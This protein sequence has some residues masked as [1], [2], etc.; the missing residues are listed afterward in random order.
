MEVLTVRKVIGVVCVCTSVHA[1]VCNIS[2][3]LF[4]IVNVDVCTCV[5]FRDYVLL[6]KML[7][8][9]IVLSSN[10]SMDE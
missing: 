8:K 4:V 7:L 5:I 6:L 2:K 1:H 10:S 9:C 3:C